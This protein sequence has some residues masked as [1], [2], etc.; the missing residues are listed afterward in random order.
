LARIRDLASKKGGGA[1]DFLGHMIQNERMEWGFFVD[2][3]FSPGFPFFLLLSS[4]STPIF[5]YAYL[6]IACSIQSSNTPP[7]VLL[8][9]SELKYSPHSSSSQSSNTPPIRPPPHSLNQLLKILGLIY[10]A[11]PL[12]SLRKDPS[13]TGYFSWHWHKFPIFY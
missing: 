6:K 3:I 1:V 4:P 7:L 11:F 2:N 5:F 10:N 13:A 12:L 9:L 8:L